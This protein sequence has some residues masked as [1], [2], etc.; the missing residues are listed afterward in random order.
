MPAIS[1]NRNSNGLSDGLTIVG[2]LVQKRIFQTRKSDSNLTLCALTLLRSDGSLVDVQ[3]WT[4]LPRTKAFYVN[5][6]V[7]RDEYYK[8]SNI[9]GL[10]QPDTR[11]SNSQFITTNSRWWLDTC[12]DGFQP[13]RFVPFSTDLDKCIETIKD[14]GTVNVLAIFLALHPGPG[15]HYNRQ[16]KPAVQGYYAEFVDEKGMRFYVLIWHAARID[17]SKYE[18]LDCSPG[19]SVLIMNCRAS[20]PPLEGFDLTNRYTLTSLCTPVVDS[21]CVSQNRIQE[22]KRKYHSN[23]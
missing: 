22:L 23:K 20:R 5:R 14:D 7:K 13:R 15:K 18:I 21:G 16:R 8:I 6:K 2:K 3:C 17:R 10:K 1:A 4:T 9:D 19:Q 11:Y 12:D